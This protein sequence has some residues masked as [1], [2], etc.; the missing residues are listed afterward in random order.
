MALMTQALGEARTPAL[1][2]R[3]HSRIAAQSDDAD[4]A[5]EHGEAALAL[6]DET[7]TRS[8]YCFALHNLALF[9][10]YSG[11]GADHAAIEKGMR[12]QRD[13][14]AWEMSTVPAFWAR[15]FDDFGTARQRFEDILRAFREQG[16][17]ATVSRRA[18]AP[19]QDR[20]HDRAHGRARALWRRRSTWPRRPS[21]RPTSTWRCARRG[22]CAPRPASW[23]R[24]G[25]R[26]GRCCGRLG[27]HPDVVLEGMARAV[28]G[29]AALQPGT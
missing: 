23:R 9:K 15:N 6:M 8:L 11:R 13:V 24:P 12:L 18:H 4:V 20:G 3:I 19:G 26:S 14:A 27:E 5:V 28:L 21:R 7:R 1:R 2:A 17:E 10:L 22:T 16:D 25:R 29:L